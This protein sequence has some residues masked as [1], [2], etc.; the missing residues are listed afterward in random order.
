MSWCGQNPFNDFWI[1]GYFTVRSSSVEVELK[2]FI[3][4]LKKKKR[5][6]FL[7]PWPI[8]RPTQ[9]EMHP[10]QVAVP[11]LGRGAQSAVVTKPSCDTDRVRGSTS[12]AEAHR[13]NQHS[14]KT[15]INICTEFSFPGGWTICFLIVENGTIEIFA[16]RTQKYRLLA[17]I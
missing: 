9:S 15:R 11:R 1:R 3:N 17:M 2:S 6:N 16:T 4:R 5:K 13:G 7:Q 12:E 10:A 14:Q 8:D